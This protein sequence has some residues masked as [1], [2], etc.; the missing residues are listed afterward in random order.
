MDPYFGLQ[1]PELLS[2]EM[3]QKRYSIL[4]Y[5]T[6]QSNKLSLTTTCASLYLTL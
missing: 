6:F 1:P 3:R 2:S 4:Q 5:S